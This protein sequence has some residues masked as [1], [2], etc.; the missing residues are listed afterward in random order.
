MS[1]KILELLIQRIKL[2][3]QI[4]QIQLAIKLLKQKRTV[5]NLKGIRYLIV[6][7]AAGDW[8]FEQV[9]NH[10]KYKWGFRSS[11]GYYIGYQKFIDFDGTLHIARRDNEEGA[12]TK[13]YNK[14]SVGI[15]LQGNMEE[16]KPTEA[17]KKTLK[18]EINKYKEAGLEIKMHQ[19][20][21]STLCPGKHLTQWLLG[22][23]L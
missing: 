4:L 6:H 13:G 15:C 2:Q 14:V 10:H 19:N 17:Q 12:H 3:L 16:R 23:A 18:E 7:H 22:L 5:P 8:S 20:F 9:N 1:K 21:S 11:L